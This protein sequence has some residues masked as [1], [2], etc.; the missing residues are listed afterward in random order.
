DSSALAIAAQAGQVGLVKMILAK[1]KPSAG[2]LTKALAAVPSNQADI[3]ELL[4]KAGAKLA[5]TPA[6][7]S[8]VSSADL[9]RYAGTFGND[10]GIEYVV[11]ASK[12]KLTLA[13]VGQPLYTL[14]P[15]AKGSF[16]DPNEDVTITFSETGGKVAS[17]TL[18]S[19]S[20]ESRFD[21]L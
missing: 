7:A 12:D 5:S 1:S 20:S 16:K 2:A 8:V 19:G 21:R 17:L 9:Q 6:P 11:A 10:K 4:K 14:S 3:S 13:W 18:K 15:A